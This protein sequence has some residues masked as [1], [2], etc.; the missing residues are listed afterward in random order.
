MTNSVV[1]SYRYQVTTYVEKNMIVET[2][3]IKINFT[4]DMCNSVV[5]SYRYQVT[6]YVEIKMT[7]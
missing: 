6:T 5:Q 3:T 7:Q 2:H 4:N 1:Q